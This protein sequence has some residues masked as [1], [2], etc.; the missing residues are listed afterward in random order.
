M[1]RPTGKGFINTRMERS[2]R[3]C[4]VT[5]NNMGMGSKYGLMLLNIVGTMIWVKNMGRV[6]L[7]GVKGVLI[8]GISWIIIYRELE[9]THGVMRGSLK[10]SGKIIRWKEKE[11]SG[12]FYFVIIYIVGLMEENT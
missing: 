1:T 11:S 3:V 6:S 5:I 4:G 7:F 10:E 9:L 12:N 2:M 8:R